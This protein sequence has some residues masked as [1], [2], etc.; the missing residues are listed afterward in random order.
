MLKVGFL[1]PK[2]TYSHEAVNEYIKDKVNYITCDYNSISDILMAVYNNE[3][4]EAVVPI[5]NSLE[6]AINVTLDTIATEVDL[7]IKA[8]IVIPIKANLM[9]KKGTIKEDIKYI[10]SHPQPLGQCRKYLN[11]HYPLA[12]MRSVYSTAGAADEV[13]RGGCES[14]AIGSKAA[15]ETYGLNIL[16][17]GIQDGDNN[18]TRFIIVSKHDSTPTGNDKTSIVFSTDDKPGSLY[19]ILDIFNLW[20]INMA[21]IESRPAKN[22]L[23]KYI[24]FIDIKGHRDEE[25]VKDALTMVMKKTSFYKLLGSYPEFQLTDDGRQLSEDR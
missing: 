18:L 4:D 22:K 25:D 12:E 1:G 23:G 13:A 10:L 6:G 8:E 11:M 3:I 24:F 17:E 14:A 19:R 7:K 2:G 9:A 21:R 16:A 15:A 5:E 20:D